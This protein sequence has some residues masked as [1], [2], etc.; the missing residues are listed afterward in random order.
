M[1]HIT[2]DTGVSLGFISEFPYERSIEIL[3][4]FASYHA[5]Q[6]GPYRGSILKCISRRDWPGLLGVELDP[7]SASNPLYYYHARQA[8]AFFEKLE[9]LELGVDKEQVAWTKF[10]EAEA[11]CRRTNAILKL[12]ASGLFYF[13][14]DIEQ[15]LTLAQ[16]KIAQILGSV[17]ASTS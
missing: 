4:D 17:P 3:Q 9:P 5:R 15:V 6:A 2:R 13:N 1:S 12:R 11:A 7:E 8:I 14:R 16:W 10:Q